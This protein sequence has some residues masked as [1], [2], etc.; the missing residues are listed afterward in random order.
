[1]TSGISEAAEKAKLYILSLIFIITVTHPTVH[2]VV[3]SARAVVSTA[4][5]V[6]S[7]SGRGLKGFV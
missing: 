5:G 4:H 1:M 2:A 7:R 3:S 6:D